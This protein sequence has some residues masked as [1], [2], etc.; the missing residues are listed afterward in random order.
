[1]KGRPSGRLFIRFAPQ[2][3]DGARDWTVPRHRITPRARH[4]AVA[5]IAAL[6]TLT[7]CSGQSGGAGSAA[8]AAA[9]AQLGMPQADACLHTTS[10][11]AVT[12][13]T[14]VDCTGDHE[15]Q[16]YALVG[17]PAGLT[18][19]SVR[20]QVTKVLPTLSCPEVKAWVGYRGNVPLGLLH[21]FR[22][23]TKAQIAA[24]ARWA[25]CIA[26]VAPGADHDTLRA[27]KGSLKN[28]LV[29]K[30][31]PLPGLGRCAPQHTNRAFV[32]TFCEAGSTQWVWLGQ[33][34]KPGGS[35]PGVTQAK[36][37]ANAGC[38]RL[39]GQHGGG[40]AWVYFPNSAARWAKARADWSCWM[41]FA[42]VKR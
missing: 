22:F 18:D 34:R 25:A 8:S 19:P 27:T 35:F 14:P 13:V 4:A 30:A 5:A 36:K 1:V 15:A 40:T 42:K 32:P 23:P 7:A 26:V 24:G 2:A 37:V 20:A 17:F 11:R 38:D 12:Q 29:G 28:R 31:S 33:H 6:L 16:V 3:P 39:V 21:T 9:K 41:P 10:A